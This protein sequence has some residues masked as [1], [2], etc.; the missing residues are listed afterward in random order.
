LNYHRLGEGIEHEVQPAVDL[1][2]FCRPFEEQVA[3]AVRG[4][5]FIIMATQWRV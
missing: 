1:N 5:A 3:F 2:R 4:H